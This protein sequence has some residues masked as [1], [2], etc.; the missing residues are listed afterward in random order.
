M[1]VILVAIVGAALSLAP[2]AAAADPTAGE[3][4]RAEGYGHVERGAWDQA[5]RA[6]ERAFAADHDPVSLYAIGRIHAQRGDCV[7]ARDAFTRFL[8]TNPPPRARASATAEL[9]RCR[10]TPR[11]APPPF[12][13]PLAIAPADTDDRP[14]TPP[15][16]PP[17]RRSFLRDPLGGVLVTSGLVAGGLGG[18]FYLR[19][20]G[21][22]CA[23]PCTISYQ[24]FVDGNARAQTWRTGAVVAGGVGAALLVGGIARWIAVSGDDDRADLELSWAPHAGGGGLVV[25]GAW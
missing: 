6:Y 19:A 21:E 25:A 17:R 15:S 1:R 13:P 24:A 11:E 7:R 18:Y 20:R 2:R 3:Q 8:E 9:D 14:P 23:D 12:E 22:L 16:P 5:V 4:L 10:P